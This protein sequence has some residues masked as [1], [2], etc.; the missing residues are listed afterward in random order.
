MR[1]GA[2]RTASGVSYEVWAPGAGS[3]AVEVQP[4]DGG[5]RLLPLVEDGAGFHRGVD[6]RGRVGDAYGFRINAGRLLPD[7][8]SRAQQTNVHGRSLVIDPR[9][10]AWT[11]ES[12]RRP[13]FR[14]L[15]LYELHVGTFSPEGTFR[16]VREKLSHLA[17]MGINA[18]EL[19]PI[20][21]FPGTRNWGYDGVLIYAPARSYGSPDDLRTLVNTAHQLGIAVILDVVY[22][23]LGPDGNYLGA[24]SPHYFCR[25]HKTPWG[26]GFN[27]DADQN[28]PV[29]EFFLENPGYW[30]EEFHIDGFRFD[31]THEIHDES[32]PHLLGEMTARIHA[33]G[34][35]AIAEDARNEARV[36]E[37]DGLG[38]DAVWADDF[39]HAIRVSQTREV[40]AYYQDFSGSVEEVVS[41][42]Q[43]G[44]IYRGQHSRF[45]RGPRG[46]A[47]RHLPPAGFIHCLSNH[48][49][50]GNRWL[51][52]RINHL[53]PARGYRALSV[54][55]CLTPGTPM[56]FMGQEWGA[57]SPFLYFTDHEEDLGKKITE[58][59]KVEFAAFPEFSEIAR[60]PDP[61]AVETFDQSKLDWKERNKPACRQILDLY[62]ECLFLRK[63]HKAF[64]PTGRNSWSAAVSS[65]EASAIELRN[66]EFLL[67]VNLGGAGVVSLPAGC[68]RVL[69][70]EEA[71]FGGS[72]QDLREGSLLHLDG[73]EAIVFRCLGP[74]QDAE[75]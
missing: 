47:C 50:T 36:L 11:D 39:H 16:G 49:Q 55:L 58:G 51:G 60:P 68:Q 21:D 61:Q 24:F 42:L 69:S 56:L 73:P 25:K 70:S 53:I 2:E 31:A 33:A 66:E 27:L 64:R 28:A 9:T 15:V 7:P 54:L 10:F 19:M 22:N 38:F 75:K 48:D 71:R 59:R 6:E 20:A 12:W 57:S 67:I 72:G 40:F 30:M 52:E 3:L 45:L 4:A 62:R 23:H 5:C 35:Y 41:A 1:A 26:D 63:T 13:A 46:T 8:R 29:R 44:W 37:S 32:Q 14:D 43:H 65:S 74:G 34:G 17:A 18:I